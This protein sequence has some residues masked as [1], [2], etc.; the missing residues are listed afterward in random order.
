MK[1]DYQAPR[2][3]LRDWAGRSF[4]S[5]ERAA[6]RAM[7]ETAKAVEAAGRAEIA[8]GLGARVGKAF[9]ARAKPKSGYS[10]K[11]SM[12]GYLRIGY[13]NIFERGQAIAPKRGP[14][15]WIPLPNCPQK[16]GR[17]RISPKLYIQNIGPLHLIKRP[18]KPAMLAGDVSGNAAGPLTVGRLRTGARNR[19][20]RRGRRTVRV[21]LFV[22]VNHAQMPKLVNVDPIYR[23]AT[24]RLPQVYAG[25]MQREI[26]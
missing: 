19:I 10:L 6:T 2:G 14:W 16:I 7:R 4:S 25:Q 21:P 17:K 5:M 23:E 26:Q 15:F 13:L 22:A 24:A 3:D 20:G 9:F 18:G 11:T 12:R 1:L 8:R